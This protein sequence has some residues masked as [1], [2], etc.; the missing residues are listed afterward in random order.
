MV[1]GIQDSAKRY[2]LAL[3]ARAIA[4]HPDGLHLA[5]PMPSNLAA[6]VDS[7]FDVTTA[8]GSSL[9]Y[10]NLDTGRV[11]RCFGKLTNWAMKLCFSH[12][13]SMLAAAT[14]SDGAVLWRVDGNQPIHF[15]KSKEPQ[16][17]EVAFSK[18]DR[19][20]FSA[21]HMGQVHVWDV[22]TG[23]L[24]R[25]MICHSDQL[26][27]L[28]TTTDGS[29]II[30]SSPS[31]PTFRVWDWR[32]GQKVAEFDSGLAASLSCSFPSTKT[33]SRWAVRTVAFEF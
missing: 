33:A 26:S 14:I 1:D 32:T 30:T 11:E 10:W 21:D 23:S 9:A 24:V 28:L 18:D 17:D 3:G 4:L 15:L 29:R 2:G 22:S 25:T 19:Y 31:D 13:G 8:K 12:N 20:L 16:V 5:G 7:S 27:G 6:T